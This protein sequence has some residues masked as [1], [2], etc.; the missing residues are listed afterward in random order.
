MPCVITSIRDMDVYPTPAQRRVCKFAFRLA[1]R[2]V[3][4]AELI[5]GWS[6]VAVSDP[7]AWTE[8]KVNFCH[9]ALMIF[10]NAFHEVR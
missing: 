6:S 2:I 4:K 7:K 3:V 10:L 9:V 8:F 5:H 1:D